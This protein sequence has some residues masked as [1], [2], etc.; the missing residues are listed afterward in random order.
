VVAYLTIRTLSAPRRP[1][2]AAAPAAEP[3][4]AAPPHTTATA[5]RA[6]LRHDHRAP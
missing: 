1:A 3:E 5:D 2:A 6:T 4:P